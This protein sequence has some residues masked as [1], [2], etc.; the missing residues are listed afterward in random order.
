MSSP[1]RILLVDDE[2][3]LRETLSRILQHAGFE[4]SAAAGAK[5]GLQLL[6]Q[7]EFHLVYMDIRMPD[8]TG[9]EM[10]KLIHIRHPELPV[11]LFTAQPDLNSALDALRGGAYDYL[12]KPLLPSILVERANSVF[13]QQNI[14]RKKREIIKQIDSLQGELRELERKEPVN[15]NF[16]VQAIAT[17]DRYIKLGNLVLDLL[18]R[19][20]AVNNRF[21][22]IPPTAFD[23]LVVLAKHSPNLVDYKTLAKEAQ[24]YQV[25]TREAQEIVKWHVY[26]VRQAIE[27]DSQNPKYLINVR[28]SGYRLV[29]E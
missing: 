2:L 17:S 4:V 22:G 18:T 16:A 19:N 25:E 15:T 1:K 9:L 13:A 10:L 3:H 24:G 7:Y 8:M 23:Y 29:P 21:V 27:P 26:H 20:L 11:I 28:G 5:D 12:I 6:E 14:E